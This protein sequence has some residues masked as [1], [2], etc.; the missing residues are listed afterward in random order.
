MAETNKMF[1][2]KVVPLDV[3]EHLINFCTTDVNYG[4]AFPPKS[5]MDTLTGSSNEAQNRDF[6]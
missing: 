4:Q 6:N 1:S 2:V 3:P 5:L